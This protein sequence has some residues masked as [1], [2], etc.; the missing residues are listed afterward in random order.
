MSYR[1]LNEHEHASRLPTGGDVPQLLITGRLRV[2]VSRMVEPAT[3][4]MAS[5]VDAA[6]P[7]FLALTNLWPYSSTAG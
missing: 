6:P 7:P 4:V 1:R 5:A 2:S 3:A